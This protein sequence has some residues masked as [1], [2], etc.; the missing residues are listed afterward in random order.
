MMGNRV[1]ALNTRLNTLQ[2]TTSRGKR[3]TAYDIKHTHGFVVLCVILVIVS[4]SV[5]PCNIFFINHRCFSGTS[6][7]VWLPRRVRNNW[8]VAKHGK[9]HINMRRWTGPALA[10]V[11]YLAPSHYPNQCS[12]I[13]NWTLRKK[14]QWN[15]KQNTTLFTQENAFENVVCEMAAI[16]SR[17]GELIP[18]KCTWASSIR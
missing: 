11:A 15:S 17:G 18:A 13:I 5:V 9:A 7:I 14:F 8:V 6:V 16:L 10:Q 12:L 4:V 2:E 1:F 3:Q